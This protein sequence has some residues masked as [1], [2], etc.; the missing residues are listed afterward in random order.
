MMAL[1]KAVVQGL[2]LDL[3]FYLPERFCELSTQPVRIA[4]L[5]LLA[6]AQSSPLGQVLEAGGPLAIQGVGRLLRI[7]STARDLM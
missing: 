3:L 4:G 6:L 2:L 5:L 7:A 1:V